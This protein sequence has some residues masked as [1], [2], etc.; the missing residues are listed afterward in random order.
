MRA[1]LGPTPEAAERVSSALRRCARGTLSFGTAAPRGARRVLG[2]HVVHPDPAT[3]DLLVAVPRDGIPTTGTEVR[4][5]VLDVVLGGAADGRCRRVVTVEGAV[6]VPDGPTQR[7]AATDIAR[8]LADPALLDVGTGAALLRLHTRSVSLV[9]RGGVTSVGVDDLATSGPDPFA[10]LEGLW[11]AHLNDARCPVLG[12]LV[13]R[14]GRGATSDGALLLG[15]DRAGL[16]VELTSR[17]G[18]TRVLRLPFGEACS[19]V[20]E[21]G[22]QIRLLA[23]C[24]R[25]ARPLRDRSSEPNVVRRGGAN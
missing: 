13:E 7:R 15:I 25:S 9:E 16:D 20:S 11:L 5:E 3:G 14:T 24:P 21:L 23:G 4:L 8:E 19:T 22:T 2:V 1:L 18:T 12:R 10:D 6:S 17:E